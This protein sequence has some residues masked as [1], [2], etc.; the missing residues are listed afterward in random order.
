ML[1]PGKVRHA[2]D[3]DF[4][5]QQLDDSS[6]QFG[7]A[8]LEQHVDFVLDLS[9]PIQRMYG[10]QDAVSRERAAMAKAPWPKRL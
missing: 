3:K 2:L 7:L 1:P 6:D 9:F 5:I 10:R 4:L 8:A